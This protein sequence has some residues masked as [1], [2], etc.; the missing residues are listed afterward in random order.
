M[1]I[2][3]LLLLPAF[4]LSG[5]LITY[6]TLLSPTRYICHQDPYEKCEIESPHPT[7]P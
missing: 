3:I 6:C 7:V 4:V 1:N 2:S 5:P